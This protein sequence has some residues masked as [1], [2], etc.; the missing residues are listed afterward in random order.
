MKSHR[1]AFTLI[2]LLV[3]IAI[4]AVL[5]A[6]LLPAVQSARE[7][8][9]RMQCTNNL[10]QLGLAV[11]NYESS[12]SVFP[13]MC[14]YPNTNPNPN[15]TNGWTI[16]W[17]V[18]LLQ[19]SE[20]STM[21]NAF[22][23]YHAPMAASTTATNGVGL[24]NTTVALS[25][26]NMLKC[27][28]DDQSSAPLRAFTGSP[29]YYGN[30]NYMG[31]AGGPGVIAMFNG[32]IVPNRN[33]LTTNS[34]PSLSASVGPVSIAS[35]TD[36]TSNTG[37]VSER[38]IG[39]NNNSFRRSSNL[40]KRGTFHGAQSVSPNTGAAGAQKFVS[41]CG[42]VAGTAAVRWGA[43]NGQLWTAAYPNYLVINSYNHFGPPNQIECTNDADTT[44][45]SYYVTP[46]GSAPPNSNHPGGV[47]VG[48]SDGSVRFVKDSINLQAWWGLGSRNLGEIISADAL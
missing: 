30:T 21:Y 43:G 27:P 18:P 32:T 31:N 42:A 45:T 41:G 8:A 37:L 28:S 19:F 44:P 13:A 6:L 35:I 3:V 22:N 24:V 11:M 5:I 40:A 15:T 38:L 33:Q 10:K 14:Q 26:L 16:S 1:R 25:Q 48:L 46:L 20:Q 39:V 47:N 4:I 34:Y 23:F 2:E 12:N 36:G 29:Y 9:R 17:I 7:A